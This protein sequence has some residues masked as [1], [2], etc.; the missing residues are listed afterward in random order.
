LDAL[1]RGLALHPNYAG[2]RNLKAHVLS[3]LWRADARYVGQAE[4]YF[5]FCADA[6]PT[7]FRPI[8]ELA[9]IYL[10]TERVDKVW[11]LLSAFVHETPPATIEAQYA[12]SPET[13]IAA[14][15]HLR[16]Y[17][18]FREF[19]PITPYLDD[20]ATLGVFSTA[21]QRRLLTWKLGLAYARM[22]GHVL[23]GPRSE[24]A[25]LDEFAEQK[26]AIGGLFVEFVSDVAASITEGENE[27][28]IRLMSVVAISI[29]ELALVETSRQLGFVA[30]VLSFPIN[31]ADP[32]IPPDL[33]EWQ[34]RLLTQVL[35]AANRQLRLLREA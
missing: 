6:A 33:A 32:P 2:L 23:E 30:G 15:R 27:S 3:T 19:S 9:H 10:R 25:Y 12:A 17:R 31:Q 35:E 16:S 4:A 29:P 11:L 34:S 1:N 8:E 18:R 13:T 24:M 26:E 28:K 20:L 21:E 7:D 5:R 14:F 22:Y